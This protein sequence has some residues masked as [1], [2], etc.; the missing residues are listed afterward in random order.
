MENS[1][2]KNT[3]NPGKKSSIEWTPRI[4]GLACN[5]CTYAGADLAGTSRMKYPENIRI[6]RIMCTGR[7]DP[8]FLLQA[9]F[10]GVDGI[11]IGGCHPG[12]CHYQSGNHKARRRVL[13]TQ[14]LLKQFGIRPERI[15]LQWISASESRKFAA[16]VQ[17]FTEKIRT[18]GPNPIKGD[19]RAS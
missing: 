15:E 19:H 10:R 14:E 2:I 16:V 6:I 9:I 7:I 13:L 11:L 4:L 5:W 18:L 8:T 3:D 12:D 17:E 1:K